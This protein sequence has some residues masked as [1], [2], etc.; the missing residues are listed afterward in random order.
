MI[1]ANFLDLYFLVVIAAVV[2]SW[3]QL[4]YNNPL[5]QFVTTLTE[6][7]LDPIRRLMPSM[8]GIDFSPMVLLFAVRILR[9]IIA[10][11]FQ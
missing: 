10:S 8:G 1:L 11:A 6:P 5:V 7:L 3:M 2:V 9:N 4:P